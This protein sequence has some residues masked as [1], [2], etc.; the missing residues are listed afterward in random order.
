MKAAGPIAIFIIHL[1]LVSS[2]SCEN[3][4]SQIKCLAFNNRF[5]LPRNSKCNPYKKSCRMGDLVDNRIATCALRYPGNVQYS[6]ESNYKIP[7]LY[8]CF[9]TL[10]SEEKLTKRTVSVDT[11]GEL[12]CSPVEKSGRGVFTCGEKGTRCVCDSP[13]GVAGWTKNRCR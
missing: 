1:I 11:A 3:N 7:S 13:E 4:P 5:M 2:N 12:R 8:R 10:E 9:P 6:L